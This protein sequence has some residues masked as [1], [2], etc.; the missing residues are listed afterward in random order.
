MGSPYGC[1]AM[2]VLVCGGRAYGIVPNAVDQNLRPYAVVGGIDVKTA[3]QAEAEKNHMTWVLDRVHFNQPIDEL[4]HGGAAGADSLAGEWAKANNVPVTI[5]PADW[6]KYGKLAGYVR[7]Q[8]MAN[9]HPDLCI[10][11]PGGKGTENMVNV[12]GKEAI[13]VMSIKNN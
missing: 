1:D 2:R 8:Q 11:F 3:E 4:I 12:A 9:T 5:F 6:K 7:N 13:K 10:A